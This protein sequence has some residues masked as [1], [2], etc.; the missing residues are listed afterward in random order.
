MNDSIAAYDKAI[1]LAEQVNARDRQMAQYR[2]N[3]SLAKSMLGDWTPVEN[4]QRR[5]LYQDAI[6]D[7][8]K[9]T[10]LDPTYDSAWGAVGQ[11]RERL[12][13]LL[14]GV[15]ART[16]F[17]EAVTAYRK[18]LEVRP[19][20]AQGSTD[21]GRCLIRWAMDENNDPIKL[22]QGRD[23]L[24]KAIKL[25]ENLGEAYYWLGRYYQLK[26]DTVRANESFQRASKAIDAAVPQAPLVQ[27]LAL[28]KLKS[29][30]K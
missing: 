5:L 25:D 22:D 27:K 29:G 23:E 2:G 14:N 17:P 30:I 3:R 19:T 18:Q 28:L 1:K 8:L 13:D 21:L 9:A 11:A 6:T 26:N 24:N 7:A 20:F 12:A 10:E 15:P 4:D 16:V